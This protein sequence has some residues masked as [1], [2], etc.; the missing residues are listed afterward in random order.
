MTCQ[1]EFKMACFPYLCTHNIHDYGQNKN[2]RQ[3]QRAFKN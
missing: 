1:M 3:Q 2:Y